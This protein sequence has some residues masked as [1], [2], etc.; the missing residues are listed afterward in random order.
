MAFYLFSGGNATPL[1]SSAPSTASP[2]LSLLRN[3]ARRNIVRP[4]PGVLLFEPLPL[5]GRSRST[6]RKLI[7]ADL[8]DIGP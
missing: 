8:M 2:D 5:Y 7:F 3:L 6:A 1:G 4:R